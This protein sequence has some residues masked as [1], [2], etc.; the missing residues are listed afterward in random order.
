MPNTN[1]PYDTDWSCL[2][3]A[4]PDGIVLIILAIAWLLVERQAYTDPDDQLQKYV[5][6]VD[7]AL[8]HL[9]VWVSHFGRPIAHR[10]L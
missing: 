10:R 4:S 5:H 1:I 2:Y 7:W 9:V 3:R 8:F 6:D